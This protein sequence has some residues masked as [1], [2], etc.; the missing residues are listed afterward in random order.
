[1]L[2]LMHRLENF[3]SSRN[4]WWFCSA[5]MLGACGAPLGPIPGGK[6]Q[7]DIAP[8]PA[9]WV[10]AEECENVLLETAPDDPYSVTIWGIGI[11]DNFYIGASK[12]SNQWVVNLEQDPRVT[13]EVDGVLYRATAKIVTDNATIETVGQKFIAKY[14]M[15]PDNLKGEGAFYRLQAAR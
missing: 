9:N 12:R 14:D 2:S 1:M 13:L 7:G 4:T 10:H 11:D 5:L 15:D 8:W 3:T 6:L